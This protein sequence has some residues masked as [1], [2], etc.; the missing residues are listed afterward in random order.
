MRAWAFAA[1]SAAMVC[2]A[3][4]ADARAQ[5]AEVVNVGTITAPVACSYFRNYE[6]TRLAYSESEYARTWG[7]AAARNYY[8]AHTTWRS[9]VVKDCETH[10]QTLR[11]AVEAALAS[12]GRVTTGRG[13]Y[14]LDITISDIG[15][16]APARNRP[17]RGED[18]YWT[19]W[20][21]AVVTA[22]YTVRDDRGAQVD[23]GFLTKRVEMSRSLDTN[24]MQVNTANPGESVY[25]LVQQEVAAAIARDVV[26]AI[27]PIRVTAVEGDLIEIN[28]GQP[29]VA[30]GDRLDVDRSRGI[31]SL[32]YRVISATRYTATAEVDGDN[33]TSD[34]DPGNTVTFVEKDSDAANGRRFRR[35]R[36]P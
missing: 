26:F 8:M 5:G 32:R 12:T 7:A 23:G 19:S 16:T 22:S 9:Y 34:I 2:A 35:Q 10:F 13:G 15:E 17:V 28:Y 6:G 4:P 30:L 1:M 36:L 18:S 25:D 21:T 11:H 3:L 27:D 14:T 20:G 29:L 33:D 24:R 31:G